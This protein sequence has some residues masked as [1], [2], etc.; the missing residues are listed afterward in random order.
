MKRNAMF[1]TQGPEAETPRKDR[2][3]LRAY[4]I[5]TKADLRIECS[6]PAGVTGGRLILTDG[7]G[8]MV[9]E[10]PLKA[11]LQLLDADVRDLSNGIYQLRSLAAGCS[12]KFTVT[13]AH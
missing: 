11:G 2:R 1:R 13:I 6:L 5:P 3:M 10:W 8:R 9:R 7:Q 12:A 4:P